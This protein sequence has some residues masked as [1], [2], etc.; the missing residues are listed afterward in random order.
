MGNEL[1]VAEA[2]RHA[3]GRRGHVGASSSADGGTLP[4]FPVAS[5]TMATPTQ[6]VATEPIQTLSSN[7]FSLSLHN[8]IDH[9]TQ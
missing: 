8:V 5:T 3:R 6:T 4:W 1:V 7:Y 9:I 2:D